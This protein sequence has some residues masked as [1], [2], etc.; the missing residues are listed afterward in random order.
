MNKQKLLE[1]FI[2]NNEHLPEQKSDQWV[3]DRLLTIGGSEMGTIANVNPYKDIRGL[4]ENHL[5]ITTFNGNINTYWGSLLEGVVIQILQ[6]E[7]NCT[8]YETGSLPGVIPEQKYSPDG[9]VYLSFLDMI[10]LLEIKCAARRIPNGR[11]PNMYKPQIYTGLDTITI[12]DMGMFVDAMF[13][14]CPL[15][16]LNFGCAY[17][18]SMHSNKQMEKPMAIGA[19]YIYVERTSNISG[20]MHNKYMSSNQRGCIDAGD[21]NSNQRGCIDAGDMNSNQRGCIDAGDMNSNQRGCIDAGACS[22]DILEML[23]KDITE[24]NLSTTTSNFVCDVKSISGVTTGI[25]SFASSR[26][27]VPIAVLPLKLFKFET[28]PVLRDSWKSFVKKKESK[29][30]VQT[31]AKTI[32][33]VVSQ[34]RELSLLNTA[35]QIST[36]NLIYPQ[37]KEAKYTPPYQITTTMSDELINSLM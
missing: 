37:S 3:K 13:R 28:I 18:M 24:H 2:S 33:H 16:D 9:L 34:I 11:I 23:L 4:V 12:A 32:R 26:N 19:I 14:R 10:I 29:S 22:D 5:G 35:E 21:M 36:L 25:S 30:F 7:W 27:V 31:Y 1:E 15:Q 20:S 17:N 8:I 6:K